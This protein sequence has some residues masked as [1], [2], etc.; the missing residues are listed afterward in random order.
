MRQFGHLSRCR[1][2]S[3]ST[4]EDRRPSKYQQI[5]WIV[6]RQLIPSGPCV[7]QS[8]NLTE[9]QTVHLPLQRPQATNRTANPY[10]INVL[11]IPCPLPY[12]R[13]DDF[14]WKKLHQ[15]RLKC[16]E[17]RRESWGLSLRNDSHV[18]QR[19]NAIRQGRV[20]A[21]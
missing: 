16:A 3:P 6:S 5:K 12:V 15:R 8:D 19:R 18:S 2:I 11:Q 13:R 10:E 14:L 7:A 21:E 4:G 1:L 17:F 20:R 9:F